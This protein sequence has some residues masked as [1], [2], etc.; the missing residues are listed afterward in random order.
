MGH[1]ISE[2]NQLWDRV[3]VRLQ[4]KLNDRHV[5]D[6]FFVNSYIYKIDSDVMT[7]VFETGLGI[8][9]VETRYSDM[10]NDI[11][12]EVTQTSFKLKFVTQAD[13]A[14]NQNV[15]VEEKPTFFK[16]SLINPK[17][18]FDSFVVGP[19]NREA[20]QAAVL[21]ASNPGKMFNPLFLHSQSGLGKTHLLHA[22]GNYI[23]EINPGLRV[24]YITTDDFV[25]EFIKYV[26]GD[27][28]SESL[29]DFFKTVDILL[30][31]DIQFLADKTKTEEMFFH[32]FNSLVSANK[33]IVL[34][35]DR[36]PGELKG[37][38]AR[39]VSRFAQGLTI[40]ISQPDLETRKEILRKKIE[41]NNLDIS[42][43]DSEVIDFFAEK[44]GNNVR[45]LEG[46]LNRLL[47]YIINGKQSEHITLETALQSVQSLTNID[48]AQTKLSETKVINVVADYY[49]LTPSQLTGRIR[50]SQIAMARHIAM[51]LIRNLLDVP[52][53]Q[54]GTLFGGK[55]H[56][57]VISAI[58]KVER[59]LKNDAD[60]TIAVSEL[61]KRLKK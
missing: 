42:K 5:F 22:M 43:F 32:I 54:I 8:K 11:V 56:S 2:V 60:L 40:T 25:E 51:Y 3:L 46:A 10:L 29:K 23:K 19:S 35:S 44:F 1:S 59:Q 7:V 30:I 48:D 20:S 12:S 4:T 18:S 17:F 57:T 15:V 28:E 16:N 49:N 14:N 34:T 58:E 13:V 52:F 26:H 45:E 55:D 61:K 24:L 36:H 6:S 41:S 47:F 31:D 50:T 39:L 37:I 33:Q 9:V 21:I 53:K 27:K 38:E